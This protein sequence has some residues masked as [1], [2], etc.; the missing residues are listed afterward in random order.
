MDTDHTTIGK[1]I[2]AKNLISKHKI[3]HRRKEEFSLKTKVISAFP[4]CGKSYTFENSQDCFRGILDSDSSEF[5]WV[6]D[7]NGKNTTERNSDFPNNYIQHIKDNL[8]KVEIIFVSSHDVVRNALKD[9]G[10]D[11][12]IVYPDKSM[13]DEWLRRF[14]KRGNDEKFIDFIS[15]NFEKFIDEIEEETFPEKVKLPYNYL[16]YLNV[17]VLIHIMDYSKTL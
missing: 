17:S 15:T 5:S 12:T 4:A 9:N 11:Y 14:K 7:E 16:E 13:K 1:L 2:L 10:I 3:R 6:K 8:G